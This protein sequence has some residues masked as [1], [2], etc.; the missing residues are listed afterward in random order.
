LALFAEDVV[1]HVPGRSA[2]AARAGVRREWGEVLEISR[3]NVYRGSSPAPEVA[4]RQPR[5]REAL[6]YDDPV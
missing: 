3:A 2:H 1:G 6:T 5:D 4:A